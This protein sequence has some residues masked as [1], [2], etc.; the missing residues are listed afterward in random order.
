MKHADREEEEAKAHM[1]PEEKVTFP[2][3]K[4]NTR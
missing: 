4:D 3:N 1:E 2:S